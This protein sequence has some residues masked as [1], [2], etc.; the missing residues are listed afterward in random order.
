MICEA[1]SCTRAAA[2]IFRGVDAETNQL[3]SLAVCERCLRRVRTDFHGRTTLRRLKPVAEAEPLLKLTP[4]RQ[5]EV[6]AAWMRSPQ[7]QR[8]LEMRGPKPGE[9][10]S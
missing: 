8:L 5:L 1:A 2:W 3:K 4:R 7:R 9:T 10:S 6:G